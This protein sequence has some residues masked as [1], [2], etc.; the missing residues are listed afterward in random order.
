M[1]RK[2]KSG[3]L[4]RDRESKVKVRSRVSVDAKYI[5]YS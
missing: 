1:E 2:K 5:D 3:N 4:L